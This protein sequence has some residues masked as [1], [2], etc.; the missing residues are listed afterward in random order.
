M[1]KFLGIIL[2]IVFLVVGVFLYFKNSN[3]VKNCTVE[4][5]ATVVDMKQELS[6]DEDGTSYMYYPIIEYKVNDDT[7][8]VVV[9]S[10]SSTPAYNIG[11][12]ISVLYNPNKKKE[13][14]VKGD[15]SSNIFSIA[16]MV[17]GVLVTGYGIKMALGK[18]Q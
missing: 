6:T 18:N 14:I 16:F 9:S 5:V 8:R 10:G 13:F 12:E 4:T 17:I 15:N 3:L 11:E 1:Q 7:V 2:G